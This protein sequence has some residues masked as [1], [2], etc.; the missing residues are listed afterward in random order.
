VVFLLNVLAFFLMGLQANEIIGRLNPAEIWHACGFA[1]AVFGVVVLVR[2]AWVMLYMQANLF[3]TIKKPRKAITRH[4]LLVSWCGMRGLVTLATA[5]SLPAV[6]PQRDLIVLSAFAVV[7]GTLVLQ[8][9]TLGPLI[10]RLAFPPDHSFGQEVAA[11]RVQILDAAVK[12]LAD[13]TDE[14]ATRLREIYEE[15]RKIAMTGNHPREVSEFDALRRQSVATKRIKLAELRRAGIID[16]DVFH[17]LEQ[18]LDWAELAAS[19]PHRVE[20]VES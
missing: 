16:D 19:S 13:R 6:F 20:M 14:I 5:L 10:Q 4:A 12:S 7:L 15:E 8:G 1:A 3:T 17:A 18:E 2:V 9:L 11:A